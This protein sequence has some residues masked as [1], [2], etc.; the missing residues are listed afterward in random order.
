MATRSTRRTSRR[1]ASR[2]SPGCRRRR[3]AATREAPRHVPERGRSPESA[4][5]QDCAARGRTARRASARTWRRR[6]FQPLVPAVFRASTLHAGALPACDVLRAIAASIPD[7]EPC[8]GRRGRAPPRGVRRPPCARAPAG[9]ARARDVVAHAGERQLRGSAPRRRRRRPGPARSG[10]R[11]SRRRRRARSRRAWHERTTWRAHGLAADVCTHDSPRR[12]SSA[13]ARPVGR[14]DGRRAGR[15]ACG[16]SSRSS[17]AQA[18]RRASRRASRNSNS[19][20]RSNSPRAQ[21]GAI[22]SGSPSASAQLDLGVAAAEARDRQRHQR[23]PGGRERRHP[24]PARA[25]AHDRRQLGLGRLELGE[26]PLGVLHERGCRP[27]SAHAAPVALDQRRAGLGLE[28][29]DGL[30]DRGLRVGQGLGGGARTTRGRRPRSGPAG[31]ARS[32]SVAAYPEHH[33][34]YAVSLYLP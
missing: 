2:G 14:A 19:S 32:A 6:S 15:R 1:S 12:S 5:A 26:D 9:A 28:R 33:A 11:R 27:R 3:H 30:R 29:G 13:Q 18:R 8:A 16:S 4:G 22:S 25:H 24:Q 17:A 21:R 31:A 23:R 7:R 34:T 10:S 20:A